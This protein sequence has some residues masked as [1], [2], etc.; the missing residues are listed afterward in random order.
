MKGI[1]TT[2]RIYRLGSL[3]IGIAPRVLLINVVLLFMVIVLAVS[4]LMLGRMS[5]SPAQVIE[6]LVAPQSTGIEGR[7]VWGIRLPRVL[8]GLFAG[9]ALGVSGAIFQSISRNALGSPDIIG[10]TTGSATG[11]IAYIVLVGQH[12]LGILLATVA[13]GTLTALVVYLLARRQGQVDSYR[14]VLI[15]IGVGATLSALNSL[16]LV[17]GNLDSAVQANV[18]LAGSLNARH[19]IHALPPLIGTLTLLPIALY[20]ARA[21]SMI[22]MGDD[23][24]RQLGVSVER[25]RRSMIFCGVVL[26]ALATGAVGPIAFIAL[27]APQL[28][29]RLTRTPGVP[30]LGA[31]VMG[32]A[33]LLS[34]DLITQ[35]LPGQ[36][37]LPIG[38][39]TAIAGG[40][41]LL[42]LLTRRHPR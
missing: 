25:T 1:A 17:K 33:L 7:I 28:I 12:T 6:V 9:A 32:A 41:Y 14:L 27:A 35:Y 30:I 19:W 8:T 5:L 4:L 42:W 18:W 23:V 34:A 36:L 15:G 31:A 2:R 11:A 21:L 16:L 20:A 39:I 26:A 40:I 29:T 10:F 37:I 24:S 38:R 3:S 22:E 13:S